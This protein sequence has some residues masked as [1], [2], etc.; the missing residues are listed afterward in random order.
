MIDPST[1]RGAIKFIVWA[2]IAAGLITYLW[3]EYYNGTLVSWYYYKAADDGWAVNSDTFK[4]ASSDEP[5]ILEIGSFERIE[6]LQAV[7]VKKGDRLPINTNGVID[8]KTV[9]EGKR[10]TLEGHTLKVT[11]P[12]QIKESTGFKYRDTFKHKGIETDPWGGAWS[13]GF[14]FALGFSLGLMAEG[15]TDM[16]GFRLEK[17]NHHQGVN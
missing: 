12:T 16:L 17:I 8:E 15:L 4:N 11:V 2:A 10:V 7:P 5:A 3:V 6:G 9:Q 14:I 13:V 1:T